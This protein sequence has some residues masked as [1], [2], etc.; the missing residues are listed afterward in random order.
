MYGLD[1][2]QTTVRCCHWIYNIWD[3]PVPY[4]RGG[5]IARGS[6]LDHL[7]EVATLLE[8]G[9]TGLLLDLDG[10]I[11]EIVSEPEDATVGPRIRS[12][13]GTLH[14]RLSLVAIVTGRPVQQALD[15]VGLEELTYVGNHGLERLEGGK[16]TLVEE[17]RRYAP[18][19]DQMMSR[20]RAELRLP[21][22]IFEHKPGSFAIHYRLAPDPESAHQELLRAI[23]DVAGDRVRLLMGKRV[24]NVLPPVNLSKGSAV[25]SLA[26]EYQLSRAILLGDDVTDLDAFAAATQLSRMGRLR[27]ICAAVIG[28]DAPEAL[29]GEAD[30]TLSSV[31]QVEDFLAWLVERTG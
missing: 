23:G 21:G 25:T 12:A 10:T 14:G 11:S 2:H 22:L 20:L 31:S 28:T 24:I 27:C 8:Q 4:P 5:E 3:G 29:E 18:F 7:D 17:A 19:L 9:P 13:L 30:Y 15:I 16:A 1:S 6:L 26:E